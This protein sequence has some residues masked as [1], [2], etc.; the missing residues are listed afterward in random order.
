[1]GSYAPVPGQ[2]LYGASKAALSALTAGLWSELQDTK[3]GVTIVFPGAIETNIA[4]NSGV[5]IEVSA[6]ASKIKMTKASVAAKLILDAVE[7]NK[8][9]VFIGQDAKLM[10]FLTRLNPLFA[11]KL[12]QKQMKDLLK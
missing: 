8:A 12:I 4:K 6:N 1:M 10:N 5:K 9:R 11:A 3:V 2:S 7:K